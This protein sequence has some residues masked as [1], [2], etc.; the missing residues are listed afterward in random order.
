MKFQVHTTTSAPD[1]S[2]PLLQA[3][4]SQHGFVPNLFGVLAESPAALGAYLGIADALK[5]TR[6][7]PVEREIV[8]LAVSAENGCAYCVAAHSTVA[9]MLRVPQEAIA[10]VRAGGGVPDPKL[11]AVR[12]FAAAVVVTRGRPGAEEL[13]V[14][15]AA[16]FDRGH[17]LDVL[18]IVA[19]K[20]L[21]NYTNH[22]AETPLDDAFAAERWA[23]AA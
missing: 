1:D 14:F 23:A 2:R 9:R 3:V 22:V 19:M 17:M 16:G 20:T 12:R 11:E 7:T 4:A 15:Q 10:A 18:A 21:S 6:L 5:R 13:Q 8:S